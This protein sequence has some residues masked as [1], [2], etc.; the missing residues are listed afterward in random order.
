MYVVI[1]TALL[2]FCLLQFLLWVVRASFWDSSN[3]VY[4]VF[5]VGITRAVEYYFYTNPHLLD[6]DRL[7][8]ECTWEESVLLG[9]S[10]GYFLYDI[11]LSLYLKEVWYLFLHHVLSF[12]IVTTAWYYNKSGFDLLLCLW[13]GEFSCPC[14]FWIFYYENKPHEKKNNK[15]M[16]I[17]EICFGLSF[18][19]CRFVIGPFL[20]YRLFM[21]RDTMMVVKLGCVMFYIVNFALLK[22]ILLQ[23]VEIYKS[24]FS[25]TKG[26]QKIQ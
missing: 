1:G 10:A 22:N 23:I 6:L 4:L 3:Y 12:V 19:I 24:F 14:C 7:G 8:S 16:K 26:T 9:I 17:N 11:P 21:S 5:G 25:K 18:L 13:L 20:V 15:W 2:C